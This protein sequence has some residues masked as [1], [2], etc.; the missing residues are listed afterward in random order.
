MRTSLG[1]P[2]FRAWRVYLAGVTGS[3]LDKGVHVYRLYC[4][5]V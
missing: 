1:E 2:T 4:E 3:F 5:A